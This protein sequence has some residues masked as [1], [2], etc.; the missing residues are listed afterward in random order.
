MEARVRRGASW[1]LEDPTCAVALGP[2]NERRDLVFL[3]LSHVV[4]A[5]S[6]PLWD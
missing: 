1:G 5:N 2:L 4:L 3:G 6:K